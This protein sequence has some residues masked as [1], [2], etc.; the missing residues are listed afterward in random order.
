MASVVR[1]ARFADL[2]RLVEI[3]AEAYEQTHY[4]RNGLVGFEPAAARSIIGQSIQRH[5]AP[6]ASGRYVAVTERGGRAEAFIIG[7][8]DR[9]YHVGDRCSATDLF[10]LRSPAS[11]ATDGVK[12]LPGFV[13]WAKHH[14]LVV[15]IT[16]GTTDILGD[17]RRV[18]RVLQRAGFTPYGSIY[19]LEIAA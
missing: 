7:V 8:V 19:R 15:E 17:H 18:G 10:W 1:P 4:A 12:L 14:P 11:P 3:M 2:P 5:G 6:T 13:A 9:I 16:C